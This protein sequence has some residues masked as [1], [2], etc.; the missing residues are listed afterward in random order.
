MIE[1]YFNI[2][3]VLTGFFLLIAALGLFTTVRAAF[4]TTLFALAS[5]FAI[6]FFRFQDITSS[7]KWALST[8]LLI[9][10]Y[11]VIFYLLI[12]KIKNL[13]EKYTNELQEMIQ[14]FD[15]R[16]TQLKQ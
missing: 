15:I 12:A 5:F 4:I 1:N 9:I 2:E 7:Y 10:F 8:F 3:I 11:L 16:S 14:N 13:Y 6:A